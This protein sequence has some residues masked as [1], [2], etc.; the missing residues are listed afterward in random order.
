[1]L[2]LS[3]IEA[4]NVLC[5]RERLVVDLGAR[6]IIKG[7]NAEG[8]SSFVRVVACLLG[9]SGESAQSLVSTDA[10]GKPLDG[11]VPEIVGLIEDDGGARYKV[12]RRAKKLEVKV[13]ENGAW[14]DAPG[15]TP[16]KALALIFDRDSS[17]A[18]LLDERLS[19]ER[20]VDKILEVAEAPGYD[21]MAALFQAGVPVVV[22][23]GDG[24]A[25]L[26]R[27]DCNPR[28][29]GFVLQPIPAGLHPLEDLSK[30]IAQIFDARTDIE[31]ARK[32]A[33]G[34]AERLSVGLTAEA[35]ADVAQQIEEAEVCTKAL[36][37]TLSQLDL[38]LE[39]D[40]AEVRRKYQEQIQAI[41]KARDVNVEALRANRDEAARSVSEQ[42]VKA[43]R[44]LAELRGQRDLALADKAR[45]D[46][47]EKALSE[48]KALA[49]R[50]AALTRAIT[51][52]KAQAAGFVSDSFPGVRVEIGEDG[53]RRLMVRASLE[54]VQEAWR[55]W[56]DTNEARRMEIATQWSTLHQQK[57]G[58]SGPS[59]A[60]V[61][62]DRGESLDSESMRRTLD[63]LGEA[64]QAIVTVRTDGDLSF[65]VA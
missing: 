52:L 54:P 4:E 22:P 34:A 35:P 24:T 3:H 30:V 5:F 50:H 1:M 40:I 45:R 32:N 18:A 58:G 17:P 27:V 37:E 47:A 59:L 57:R 33:A 31:R 6:T 11:V 14:R 65:E 12:T 64:G 42:Y 8:K 44:D 28:V 29:S 10:D 25:T 63:R 2:R 23:H 43:T 21:R 16:D 49:D 19:D 15:G 60:L 20:R 41:E 46:E 62:L 39:I 48:A 56:S 13:D 55:A 53:K 38:K 26:H 51:S 61:L 9:Q 36:R 7:R